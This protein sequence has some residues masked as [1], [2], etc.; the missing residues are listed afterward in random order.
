MWLVMLH[1]STAREFAVDLPDELRRSG[2]G[3]VV[4][5]VK[6]AAGACISEVHMRARAQLDE[7]TEEKLRAMLYDLWLS[8]QRESAHVTRTV[9]DPVRQ[10]RNHRRW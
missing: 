2:V 7:E 3:E 4:G 10:H 5:P 6:L 9:A 8:S 1:E